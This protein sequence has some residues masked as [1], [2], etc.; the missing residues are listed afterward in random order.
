MFS[1]LVSAA[2][3]ITTLFLVTIVFL[4]TNLDS[5]AAVQKQ[6]DLGEEAC[7]ISA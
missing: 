5:E 6:K 4:A 3:I 1:L 2:I 7:G